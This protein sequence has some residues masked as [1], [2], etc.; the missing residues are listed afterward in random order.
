MHFRFNKGVSWCNSS[1]TGESA[2]VLPVN[3]SQLMNFRFNKKSTDAYPVL[4]GS[5]LMHFRFNTKSADTL[6]VNQRSHL[7]HFQFN[8]GVSWCTS[9][10]TRC[11]SGLTGS[12]LNDRSVTNIRIRNRIRIYRIRIYR[13]RIYRIRINRIRIYWIRIYRIRIYRIRIYRIRNRIRNYYSDIR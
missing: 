6:L 9:G 5:Q 1:Y 12:Q 3:R 8:R 4:S 2:D 11:N 7:I 13:I 10:L